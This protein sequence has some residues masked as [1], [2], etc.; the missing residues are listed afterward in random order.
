MIRPAS[1]GETSV[2]VIGLGAMGARIAGRILAAGHHLIV[3]NRTAARMEPLLRLG[4]TAASSPA[5]AASQ[6]EAVFTMVS[7]PPALR[8]V[9]EGPSGVVAGADASTTVVQ[10]ST[11]GPHALSRLASVLPSGTGLLDAPVMG[12]VSE[13]ESGALTIFV[14]GSS[15]L[16]ERWMPLLSTLGSVVVVGALGAGT[17]AKLVTNATL[18]GT[19]AL[20]GESLALGLRLGLPMDVAF[21]VLEATPLA[22]QAQ[23][24]RAAIENH[25]YPARFSLR[26]ARKDAGLIEEAATAVGVDLPVASTVRT[27]LIEADNAGWGDRDYSAIVA[28]G[29]RPPRGGG[30]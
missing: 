7:D 30:G 26:L 5:E 17:A 29:L 15:E 8:D 13:A 21:G 3:W 19:V 16:V 9:A 18:F 14:G 6:A 12:S 27:L 1:S 20:L 11:A 25:D 2:A 10:M 23:R 28:R 24:R 4:A 22:A